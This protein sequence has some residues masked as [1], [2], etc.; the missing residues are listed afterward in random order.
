MQLLKSRLGSAYT[1]PVNQNRTVYLPDFAEEGDACFIYCPEDAI[2]FSSFLIS[3]KDEYGRM[4]AHS[5]DLLN[6]GRS[7]FKVDSI[8]PGCD[9]EVDEVVFYHFDD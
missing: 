4:T 5:Y 9:C 3:G 6:N 2:M 7:A 8:C 1:L